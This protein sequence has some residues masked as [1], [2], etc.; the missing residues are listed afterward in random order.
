LRTCRP[1]R[2]TLK[3]TT[4]TVRASAEQ[5]RRWARVARFLKCRS[6]SAWLEELAEETSK[7]LE[8]PAADAARRGWYDASVRL[9]ILRLPDPPGSAFPEYRIF[10]LDLPDQAFA[11]PGTLD[12]RALAMGASPSAIEGLSERATALNVGESFDIED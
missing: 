12:T 1:S 11:S 6:V 4:F 5:A 7:R 8:E 9:R 10:R 3:T 2:A